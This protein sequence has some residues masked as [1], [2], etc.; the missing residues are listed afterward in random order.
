MRIVGGIYRGREISAKG[1]SG[2][3]TMDRAREALLNSIAHRYPLEA[4]SVLDLFAGTRR[5]RFP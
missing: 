4:Y 5:I 2:R 1:F 3:P